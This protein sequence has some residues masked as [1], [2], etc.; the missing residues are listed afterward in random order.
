MSKR[1]EVAILRNVLM[2]NTKLTEAKT[3]FSAVTEPSS[4]VPDGAVPVQVSARIQNAHLRIG[5]LTPSLPERQHLLVECRASV[6][7]QTSPPQLHQVRLDLARRGPSA[8]RNELVSAL[9]PTVDWIAFVDDD[10][11]LLPG[12][13]E[14]LAA[15]ASTSD[16]VYS[17]CHIDGPAVPWR[18][19][20]FDAQLL[21]HANYIPVTVLMRR[22]LFVDL[23]G[24]RDLNRDEDWDLWKRAAS[25]GARFHF[26]DEAT[27]VYRMRAESRTLC[28]NYNVGAEA[29]A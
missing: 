7:A 11:L 6:S 1:D 24:F 25:A 18:V 16:I 17:R 5:V 8:V 20:P 14:R 26:V 4:R 23:K 15:A 21:Q 12:H 29:R 2:G 27:W 28:G 13:L 19:Q 9:P 3:Q 10:D 22:S